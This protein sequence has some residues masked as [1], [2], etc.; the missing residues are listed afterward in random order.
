MA[1]YRVIAP[2]SLASAT[3]NGVGKWSH[4]TF[5][6]ETWA[7]Y[8]SNNYFGINSLLNNSTWPVENI[9]WYN[10][11]RLRVVSPFFWP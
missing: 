3:M 1:F 4:S 2:E 7:N 11:L 6:T 10:L 8:L 5:W 9:S